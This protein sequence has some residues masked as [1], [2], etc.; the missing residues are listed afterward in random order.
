MHKL[1]IFWIVRK[2]NRAS[3]TILMIH[4]VM[5]KNHVQQWEPLRPRLALSNYRNIIDLLCKNFNI[6]SLDEAVA[7]L[8]NERKAISNALVLTFDDGYRNNF[9]HAYPILKEKNIPAA[10]FIATGL[11]KNFTPYWFD[12]FDF[13]IQRIAAQGSEKKN[14]MKRIVV[15]KNERKRLYHIYLKYLKKTRRCQIND[16]VRLNEMES[17]CSKLEKDS[18]FN[19]K[20]YYQNDDWAAIISPNEIRRYSKDPNVTIGSHSV[21]H[22]RL[23]TIPAS[24]VAYQLL[25]SKKYIENLTQK[26]CKYLCYPEGAFNT[27]VTQIS[28]E[29]GYKA[30]LTTMEGT[31]NIGDDVLTLKRFPVSHSDFPI[32]TLY[33]AIA[34]PN[35]IS[36]IKLKLLF[37]NKMY[38][39]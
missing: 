19:F 20:D 38:P 6:I 16:I 33:Q 25:E 18:N 5:D 11:V 2:I 32:E 37:K 30:A 3:V 34:L 21:D 28:K 7:I 12:R 29:V 27:R 36:D 1:G 9:T 17:I 31:N 14:K 4:G 24:N 23:S 35:Y 8:K 39:E 10:F 15:S 13:L 26:E 22:Y